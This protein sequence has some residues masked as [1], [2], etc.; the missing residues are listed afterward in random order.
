MHGKN[1]TKPRRKKKPLKMKFF[2]QKTAQL[3]KC[4]RT[5]KVTVHDTVKKRSSEEMYISPL[6]I[7]QYAVWEGGLQR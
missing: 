5:C 7:T 4:T 3:A 6:K 1:M 2:E